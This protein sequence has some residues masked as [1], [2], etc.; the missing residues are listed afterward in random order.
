MDLPQG[1]SCQS[2]EAYGLQ[3]EVQDVKSTM[4]LVTGGEGDEAGD[5]I[6][7]QDEQGAEGDGSCL[8][9]GAQDTMEDYDDQNGSKGSGV[10]KPM[11][12]EWEE[13]AWEE[14]KRE[15]FAQE[16][17]MAYQPLDMDRRVYFPFQYLELEELEN[18]FLRINHPELFAGEELAIDLSAT[19][20][21]FRAVNLKTHDLSGQTS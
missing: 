16:S 10:G 4:T 1:S 15:E 19:E 14:P 11:Q 2:Q 21:Q 12:W 5:K 6:L 20:T 3:E 17:A 8:V 9:L 13:P 18:I 7:C